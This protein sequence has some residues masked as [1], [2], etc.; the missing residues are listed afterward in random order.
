[1]KNERKSYILL[2][3]ILVLAFSI[4]I[5]RAGDP[6]GGYH[7]FNEG[8]YILIAMNYE[9]GSFLNPTPD[10]SYIFLETPPFYSYLLYIS[11]KIFGSSIFIARLVSI[12]SSLLSII[13]VYLLGNLLFSKKEG[14]IAAFILSVIPMHVEVG[15]NIQ[16]DSTYVA[17][18]LLALYFYI[19]S[20]MDNEKRNKILFGIFFGLSLFTKSFAIFSMLTIFIWETFINKKGIKWI[21]NKNLI[22]SLIII[23]FI[24]SPF[25]LYQVIKNLSYFISDTTGGA[26]ITTKFPDADMLLYLATDAFW[27]FSPLIA[28]VLVI[29]VLYSIYLMISP[30]TKEIYKN[31]IYLLFIQLGVYLLFY[32]FVHKHSYYMLMFSPLL[33]IIG[34]KF[35]ALIKNRSL[36]ILSLLFIG[37]SGII[38]S[39]TMLCGNKY[40][41]N[42]F[43]EFGKYFQSIK[44]NNTVLI[45]SNNLSSNYIREIQFYSAQ[46]PLYNFDK[47]KKF[48]NGL[49]NLPYEKDIYIIQDVNRLEQPAKDKILFN[50]K[51][52]CLIVFGY[53][54]YQKNSST[55]FFINGNY[56]FL[57]KGKILDFGIEEISS[58]P[59]LGIVKLPKDNNIFQVG[60]NILV[61]PKIR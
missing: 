56:Y 8:N 31:G 2:F 22:L 46:T 6:I 53:C 48:E 61:K 37:I 19:R 7:G 41:Y 17:L 25:Y 9:N 60:T 29:S 3:L 33:A 11:F 44:G 14:L 4:R 23:V 27:A 35:I 28:I 51:D 34:G 57:K 10:G 55:H 52:Y 47:V 18:L 59:F 50:K 39:L 30:N 32:L 43:D 40:G 16:T 54:L 21:F 13:G 12:L 45:T 24:I 36:L 42:E 38:F 20:E 1:M 15:R 58:Y 26:L 49:L 5:Y